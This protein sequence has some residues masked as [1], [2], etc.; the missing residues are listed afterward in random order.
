MNFNEAAEITITSTSLLS[1]LACLT[2]LG[3]YLK[4]K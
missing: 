4:F 1:T 2:V 3:F